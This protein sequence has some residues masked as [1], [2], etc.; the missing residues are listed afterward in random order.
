MEPTEP[1]DQTQGA[2]RFAVP[3]VLERED[4]AEGHFHFSII[5]ATKTVVQL[6]KNT[7]M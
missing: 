5:R 3:V 7:G 4:D 1:S 2:P 6:T